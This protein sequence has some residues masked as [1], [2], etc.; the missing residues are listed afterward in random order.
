MLANWGHALSIE[1]IFV[2]IVVTGCDQNCN[3]VNLPAKSQDR[4]LNFL[5]CHWL[6]SKFWLSIAAFVLIELVNRNSTTPCSSGQ[7][8]VSNMTIISRVLA[9]DVRADLQTRCMVFLIISLNE[10]IVLVVK[11]ISD[12]FLRRSSKSSTEP[13]I[14]SRITLTKSTTTAKCVRRC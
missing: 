3:L 12:L 8:G 14:C 5:L 4:S 7:Q 1:I 13:W 2:N 11:V 9:L 10:A 6:G